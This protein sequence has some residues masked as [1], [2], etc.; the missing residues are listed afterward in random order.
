MMTRCFK[1]LPQTSD[2]RWPQDMSEMRTA[3]ENVDSEILRAAGLFG[4]SAVP[5]SQ[6]PTTTMPSID[7]MASESQYV[8]C[9]REKG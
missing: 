4:V 7:T 3:V 2:G 1:Q 5:S 8:A 9:E 6:Q